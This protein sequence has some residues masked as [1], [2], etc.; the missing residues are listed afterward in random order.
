M[1]ETI[2]LGRLDLE[3]LSKEQLEKVKMILD[4]NHVQQTINE[5]QQRVAE[6]TATVEKMRAEA[7]KIR[8]ESKFYPLIPIIL[9]VVGSGALSALITFL[10]MKGGQ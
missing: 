6:S 7:D 9:G 2:D 4:L 10:L 1:A 5:S 3:T 8:K